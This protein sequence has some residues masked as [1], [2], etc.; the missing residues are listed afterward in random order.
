M[1]EQWGVLKIDA[2]QD[3]SSYF[4]CIRQE[5]PLQ[6]KVVLITHQSLFCA[7]A[8]QNI[9]VLLSQLQLINFTVLGDLYSFAT[10]SF[11]VE[12]Q[13]QL[14]IG[15]CWVFSTSWLPMI[16]LII[17]K[18][19]IAVNIK[20]ATDV[21]FASFSFFFPSSVAKSHWQCLHFSAHFLIFSLQY[22]QIIK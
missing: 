21:L 20:V 10:A 9:H 4:S 18:P 15:T 5:F 17:I 22:G 2:Y 12:S 8:S 7:S 1:K 3:T 11:M 13:D 19:M 6:R 16:A 14:V